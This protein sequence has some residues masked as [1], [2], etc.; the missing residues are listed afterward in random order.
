MQSGRIKTAT[1]FNC[2]NVVAPF[3]G[4]P[5]PD[6]LCGQFDERRTHTGCS[7]FCLNHFGQ[8][9]PQ[10]NGATSF[11]QLNR[12][13]LFLLASPQLAHFCAAFGGGLWKCESI[14]CDT[15]KR[16]IILQGWKIRDKKMSYGH[17]I[18]IDRLVLSKYV[19]RFEEN[20]CWLHA[21][22]YASYETE[23]EM[24]I[25]YIH[26]IA[27]INIYLHKLLKIIM[28]KWTILTNQPMYIVWM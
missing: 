24:H 19:R 23:Q 6:D 15:G 14:K 17:G 2:A 11:A 5:G 3:L 8:G 18:L 1:L 27:C 12:M 22:L 10:I 20:S 9:G 4:H 28:A 21:S 7:S 13:A 26:Y 16:G 25:Q